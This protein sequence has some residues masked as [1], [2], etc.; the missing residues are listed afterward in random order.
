MYLCANIGSTKLIR[1]NFSCNQN[2]R[3][4]SQQ[5]Q[6][7]PISVETV[8]FYGEP[9]STVTVTE[10]TVT[11]T[12]STVTVTESTATVTESGPSVY[13]LMWNSNSCQCTFHGSSMRCRYV[14]AVCSADF[15]RIDFHGIFMLGQ[16]HT[17]EFKHTQKEA[18]ARTCALVYL[19]VHNRLV[20]GICMHMDTQ[21]HD[22][23][24]SCSVSPLYHSTLEKQ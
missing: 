1:G 13:V 18:H 3:N 16:L 11:V 2:I 21:V 20:Y 4:N 15:A 12:E 10:S 5:P 19:C 24:D 7:E 23:M 6:W 14:C 22:H 9:E 8:W 17:H